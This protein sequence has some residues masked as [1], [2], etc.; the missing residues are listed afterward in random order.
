M[1][2]TRI[3]PIILAAGESSRMGSAKALLEFGGQSSLQQILNCCERSGAADPIVVL[4]HRAE[5]I[6]AAVPGGV[7]VVVNQAYRRGQTS[8][9][10]T[11][12]KALPPRAD[13]FLL[14]PVDV[15]LVQVGTIDLL[16]QNDMAIVVPTHGGKRGHPALCRRPIVDEFLALGDDDPAHLVIRKDPGRVAEIAVD[17]PAVVMRLNLPEDYQHWL[18]W[19]ERQAHDAP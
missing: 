16:L 14:F 11:G 13:G 17:D 4:G 7:Q 1:S 19:F 5:D 15:P 2:I 3:T 18:A 9:L 12:L 8:T 6:A 10:K